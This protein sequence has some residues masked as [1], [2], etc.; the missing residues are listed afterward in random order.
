MSHI[1][2]DTE[3]LSL[4]QKFSR[5]RRRMRDPEWRRYLKLVAGGKAIGM[6]VVLMIITVV[7]GLFFT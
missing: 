7:S 1:P 5:L 3:R 6:L 2:R 4:S